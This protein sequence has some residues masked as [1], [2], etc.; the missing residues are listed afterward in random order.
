MAPPR[1]EIAGAVYHVNSK[2]VHGASLFADESDRALFLRL[3]NTEAHQSEWCVFAYSLM[4]NHFHLL[5]R[6]EKPTLS[7]GFQRLNSRYAR[8]YNR[9]HGRRGALWQ[10]RFFDSMVETE[11]HFYEAIRYIAL[12]APRAQLC[13]RPEEWPW[14]G[15]GSALGVYP[16]DPLVNETELLGLFAPD[17]DEARRR[18]R[19]FVEEADPR[20]RFGQTPVRLLSDAEK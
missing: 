20:A 19:S 13:E 11:G 1:I 6:L 8:L 15:Y 5:L 7:S 4:T 9:R 2:S 3:L 10:R 18:L 16:R 12:N 17:P 14:S